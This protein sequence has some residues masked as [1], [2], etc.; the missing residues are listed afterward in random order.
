MPFEAHSQAEEIVR[1]HFY[2]SSQG[3]NLS[4]WIQFPVSNQACRGGVVIASPISYEHLHSYRSLRHLADELAKQGFAV[5]RFDW[6][7]CGDSAGADHDSDRLTTWERNLADAVQWMQEQAEQSSV[8]VVGLRMGASI[9]A[10]VSRQFPI[11]NLVLWAP[12]LKGKSYVREMQAIDMTGE[13]RSQELETNVIEAGG[14]LLNESTAAEIGTIQLQENLPG[15]QELLVVSDS[16]FAADNRFVS[17]CRNEGIGTDHAI[18]GGL[19]EM[20]AEPHRSQVPKDA[21]SKIVEWL[22]QRRPAL[23]VPICFHGFSESSSLT[24]AG[25]QEQSIRISENPDL[26]GIL[27]SPPHD[28]L[29]NLP[30]VLLL[31]AGATT[32]I[33]PGRLNVHL[34]RRLAETGF[35]SF[36]LDFQ[37]LGDSLQSIPERE[38]DS[39]AST[40]FRDI[41]ITIEKLRKNHGLKSCVL[42]GLCSG[43]YAS[44]QAAAQLNEAT[45]RESILINPLTFFWKEGMTIDDDPGRH[46][47]RQHYYRSVMRDP[48]KWVRFLTGRSKTGFLGAAR[49]I[50]RKLGLMLIKTG[51]RKSPESPEPI[52]EFPEH[53]RQQN[54]SGDLERIVQRNRHLTM[55]FSS[56]DPGYAILNHFARKTAAKLNRLGRLDFKFIPNADHTFSREVPRTKLIEEIVTHLKDRYRNPRISQ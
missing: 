39:Y 31:N 1:K 56:S 49:I 21:L 6:H 40:V 27:T 54:L 18:I 52:S 13:A 33:G 28:D 51:S 9:A 19:R 2:L 43:A 8:S 37:G 35:R 23:E 7:G 50:V 44:F 55:F 12:I 14:F 42:V 53:P 3:K 16:D 38:N 46:L 15:C 34:A 24:E 30:V 36:R 22:S 11:E 48:E 26:F 10:L 17:A 25:F 32:R 45:I 4:A 47:I 20:L 41:Q 29:S 5:L